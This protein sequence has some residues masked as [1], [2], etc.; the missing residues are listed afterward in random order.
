M[1]TFPVEA[2]QYRQLGAMSV[3]RHKRQILLFL[4]AILVPAGVLI[5]LAGRIMSQDRELAAKRAADQRQAAVDQ[6]GRELTSRLEAIKLQE[7][8]RLMR[9]SDPKST[10]GSANPAVIFT[11]RVENDQAVL[12][13]EAAQP[14][15]PISR[16]F[17]QHR[18]AGEAA[19]FIKKD[20]AGAAAAYRLAL[21]AA[22]HA[23]ESP[24][25]ACCWRERYSR[26]ETPRRHFANIAF[27]ST[28][29]PRSGT[30]KESASA[31]TPQSAC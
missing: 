21:A 2:I 12:P 10:R 15:P 27:Y 24:R 7:I 22:R 5:G 16:E 30:N 29:S 6:L 11:A 14:D 13:W 4:V 25:P 3:T 18:E 20:Y 9:S 26:R 28:I 31:S 17:A 23:R 19:E 1:T 8:N